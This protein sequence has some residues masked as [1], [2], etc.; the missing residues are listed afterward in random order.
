MAAGKH[1]MEFRCLGRRGVIAG[2]GASFD[3][4]TDSIWRGMLVP[5]WPAECYAIDRDAA[6][7]VTPEGSAMSNIQGHNG[8]G[9]SENET[10]TQPRSLPLGVHEGVRHMRLALAQ[11]N[12]DGR[13]LSG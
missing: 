8:Q 3:A 13:R 10:A 9:K 4:H 12:V 6:E 7:G 2:V 5:G 11:I 1:W